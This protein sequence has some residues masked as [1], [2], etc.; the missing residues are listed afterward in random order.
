MAYA[1]LN[2]N[3]FQGAFLLYQIVVRCLITTIRRLLPWWTLTSIFIIFNTINLFES[4][5]KYFKD[6]LCWLAVVGKFFLVILPTKKNLTCPIILQSPKWR[7]KLEIINRFYPVTE[8]IKDIGLKLTKYI[9]V[10]TS[11]FR[12]N[13]RNYCL[14]QLQIVMIWL[15]TCL[16]WFPTRLIRLWTLLI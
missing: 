2:R 16:I 3:N 14:L 13:Q 12:I 10:E 15:W 8:I 1:T 6:P 7:V 5:K 9:P 4:S 11:L